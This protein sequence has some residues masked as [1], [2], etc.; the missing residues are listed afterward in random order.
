M[1]M[2]WLVIC[3]VAACGRIDFHELTDDRGSDAGSADGGPDGSDGGGSS[4]LD[5]APILVGQQAYVKASNTNTD[6]GFGADVAISADGSTMA[7]G[8]RAEASA[9][10]GIDGNQ[11][12]NSAPSAGAVYVFTRSGTTWTQQAYIKASNTN[13][14]DGFGGSVALSSDGSLLAVGAPGEA[15]SAQ[16]INGNQG[17]NSM[18]GAGAVYVFARS[19]G[20][21]TQT[22]YLKA[23]NTDDTDGFGRALAL[24][25]DGTTLA[26]GA[27]GEESKAAGIDGDQ[28]D[29]SLTASGAVYVFVSSGSAWS[30]QAYIKA[31]NPDAY[32]AFG[33]HVALSDDGNTLAA[34][35]PGEASG[36]TV[37]DGDQTDNTF[38]GA[39]AV[40]LFTRAGASWTQQAYVKAFNANSLDGFGGS[41]ALS[42]DGATLAVGA[43]WEE[44]A[45]TGIDGD[46]FLNGTMTAGAAYVFSHGT[47]WTQSAYVKA[48]NT[49]TFQFF[50][51]A[52]ALNRDGTLLVV[53][54]WGES[55]TAA[56][57][58]GDQKVN[59]LSGAGAAYRFAR[60]TRGWAQADY[61]KSSTP[62]MGAN[63]G[64]PLALS[65]D[66]STLAIAAARESSNATGIN[67]NQADSSAGWAGA[68]YVFQ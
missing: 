68:V 6:D 12:N 11:A 62:R 7:V 35:A 26:V 38:D 64:A 30:Q 42:G 58:N 45:A 21:W 43:S 39:G 1:V 5:V 15:S 44:S 29:N 32:D 22:A 66:G 63:F 50:G 14:G 65:R 8:A 4:G 16:G 52:V 60:L 37:I 17:D 61:I 47:R 57:L 36:A 48:S 67:G 56:G 55:S 51:S 46:Q 13:R 34:G 19:A 25:A 24:S 18:P 3:L 2:R 54:A 23:S 53:G 20:V 59:T 28:T 49:S 31:S 41:V 9:A 33:A 27:Q 10:T 40:Y